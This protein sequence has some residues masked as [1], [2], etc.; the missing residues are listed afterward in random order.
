LD[1]SVKTAII[2]N[3]LLSEGELLK[4]ILQDF[5]F[6]SKGRTKHERIEALNRFLL[7]LLPRGENAVLIIDEAQNL[8]IPIL[9]QIRILSNLETEKEKMLQIVLL[10]QLELDKKLQ[11][12]ELR[13]LNQRIAIRHHLLPLSRKEMESYI[14]QRLVVADA[15]GNITF[16]KSALNEIFKFSKGTPRLINL[17][18]DRALLGG[19]IQETFHIDKGIVKK[20][21]KSLLGEEAGSAPYQLSVLPKPITPLSIVL[22]V[23]FFL[24]L[25]GAILSNQHYVPPIQTAK[26]FIWE[27]I[28]GIQSQIS[29]TSASSISKIPS[30]RI[31]FETTQDQKIQPK[32]LS[33]DSEGVA[34]EGTK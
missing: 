7:E 10:G 9:E 34:P 13:Q 4:S 17:L 18:C 31:Q 15:Q 14:Y 2:F 28:Q 32:E 3:S 1:K 26:T 12:A 16:S 19:F 24:L 30:N 25:G 29:G 33:G 27:T 6:T 20:A 22:L 21:Q 8:S 5:G 11:T 23:I